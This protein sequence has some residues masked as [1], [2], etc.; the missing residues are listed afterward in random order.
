MEENACCSGESWLCKIV[1]CFTSTVNGEPLIWSSLR[2]VFK[3]LLVLCLV[4][5]LALLAPCCGPSAWPLV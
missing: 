2:M 3:S 1:L 4:A 5:N